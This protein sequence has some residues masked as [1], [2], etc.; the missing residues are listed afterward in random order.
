MARN[1]PQNN[2][3]FED[4]KKNYLKLDDDKFIRI[5]KND[6]SEIETQFIP[7]LLDEIKRR[8][9]D[10]KYLKL[11]KNQ[12]IKLS[13]AKREE[14]V[15][16]IKKSKCLKCGN[17][18]ILISGFIYTKATG[19]L[20]MRNV[21]ENKMVICKN[22]GWNLIWKTFFWNLGFGWWSIKGIIFNPFRLLDD[23]WKMFRQK[24]IGNEI[25]DDLIHCN[26]NRLARSKNVEILIEK[27]LIK[28]NL[29][30]SVEEGE[31]ELDFLGDIDWN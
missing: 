13:S 11:V 5:L 1:S 14:I 22:C 23:I 28:Y 24:A 12:S 29:H 20:L 6:V 18:K 17:N 19:Y 21:E 16:I 3:S 7:I 25:I 2:L 9:L 30:S 8:K 10:V 4:I 27:I 26:E 31:F 15:Q